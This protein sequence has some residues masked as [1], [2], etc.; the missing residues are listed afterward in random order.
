MRRWVVTG[1]AGAGK[2]VF[3]DF[4][5]RAGAAVLDGDSLGHQV[6]EMPEISA[7]LAREFGSRVIREGR[8]DRGVLGGL[9]FGDPTSLER[10]NSI[11]HRPLSE[12]AAAG[13]A[14]L[15]KAGLHRLA[16]L[17]AAVY[18]LLPPVPGVELVITVTAAEAVRRKRLMEWSG[19]DHDAARSRIL[20]QRSLEKGWASADV[21]VRNEGSLASLENGATALLARLDD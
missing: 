18:F 2:S 4:L 10:L 15:E 8:V 12:L 11:T 19:L 20:V 3:C 9:V 17:E 6:L 14:D 1:P 7:A 21:V 5:A 16:V 13:M